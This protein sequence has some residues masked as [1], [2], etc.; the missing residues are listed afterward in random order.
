MH[1]KILAL[2]HNVSFA[3]FTAVTRRRILWVLLLSLPLALYCLPLIATGN[4]LAPGDADYLMQTQEAMRK[5]LLEYGQ[6][7]WWNPWVSGGV[8]LFA[9]PQFG[10]YSLPTITSI[11]FGSI[12][13]YKLALSLYLLFG[14]W[15]VYVLVNKAFGTPRVTSILLAYI[16]SFG[17]FF[18]L[19]AAGHYTFFTIQFFP[20]LLF[21]YLKRHSLR[22]SYI[23][24]GITLGLMINAATHNTSIMSIAVF[25][26]FVFFS[27]ITASIRV[28]HKTILK[29][30]ISIDFKEIKFLVLTG[31]VALILSAQKL[32]YSLQYIQQ[33]PRDFVIPEDTIGVLNGILAMFGP[34]VQYSNQPQVP[35]WSWMEV[36]AYIG[37]FTGVAALL[38]V[39]AMTRNR[40]LIRK[41]VSKPSALLIICLLL[42]FFCLGLGVFVGKLSPYNIL[43]HLPVFSDMR[44][45]SRWIVWSSFMT[46]LLI[47]SYTATKYR[48][49]INI[50]LLLSVLELFVTGAPS[51]AAQ[52]S[53]EPSN[54]YPHTSL[55]QQQIHY[56]TK[57]FGVAYDE[58][59]TATTRA[60]IGQVV[61]GDALI[62][63]RHSPPIGENTVRCDS[64]EES[65]DFVTTSNAKVIKWSPNY[66][67]L[68]R[69]APGD[70]VL[71]MNPG[72]YW[73]VNGSYPF[74]AMRVAEP[75]EKF[76]IT[77]NADMITLRLQ[78]KFSLAWFA[79]KITGR[80]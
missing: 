64:D 5:S 59:L 11:I 17:S 62:D 50:F 28:L 40:S 77:D 4:K 6:F 47:A 71:N 74:Y 30:Q 49:I 10:L 18:A 44:V 13:G 46:L 29:V 55:I 12:M 58:N 45:A 1:E 3:Y 52:Y 80:D 8:P 43:H 65:C 61:A 78:P 23:W 24:L 22:Y 33:Y 2:V 66:I 31:V 21:F 72:R 41:S 36:S 68:D 35:Q 39:F 15:G 69:T 53:I 76:V 20:F 79:W 25:G 54:A 73:L 14:F 34:M 48:R 19:R 51:M 63:T 60:N 26:L 56:D 27:V 42:L 67:L 37:V 32:L 9:N 75:S 57:R 16:W 70:I 7:P 38:S